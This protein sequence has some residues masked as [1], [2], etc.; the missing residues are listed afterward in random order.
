M[1]KSNR[2]NFPRRRLMRL[3]AWAVLSLACLV[4]AGGVAAQVLVHD[5]G[6]ITGNQEGFKSQLAKTISS[7]EKQLQQLKTQV[8]QY[9]T[10]LQQYQ[11]MLSTIQNIPNNLSLSTNQ[12]T[13]LTDTDALIRGKC[14]GT[15]SPGGL[16]SSLMNSMSSLMSQSITQT[17]QAICGQIVITQV[18]QYNDTVDM[19][20]KLHDQYG[21]QYQKLDS[22][23][24]SD[25]SMADSGRASGQAQ[26][27][28]DGLATEMSDWQ[29]RM[30]ADD[31]VIETLQNQQSILGR[32]AMRGSSTV[33]GNVIQA[34]TFA[35]AFH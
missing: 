13:H 25:N 20:N 8:D 22:L 18:K 7:Y 11:Q 26:K 3:N 14:S 30:K 31:A 24:G 2:A 6:V 32:V 33:L 28:S 4:Y 17:Q 10:Q 9:T 34:T 12:L 27:Y 35:A 5:Q 1:Q 16:V 19:I 15:S 21:D 29:A 23:F